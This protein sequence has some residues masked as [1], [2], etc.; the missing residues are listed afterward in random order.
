M[1]LTAYS[2]YLKYISQ[3][4]LPEQVPS[5]GESKE[6]YARLAR[7]LIIIQSGFGIISGRNINPIVIATLQKKSPKFIKFVNDE[8][9]RLCEPVL[10]TNEEDAKK[11]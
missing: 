4:S 6:F 3:Q 5:S 8:Y 11:K 7:A 1:K 2:D 10:A 9:D